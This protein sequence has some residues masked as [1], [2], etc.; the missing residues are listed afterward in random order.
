[1]YCWI[2]D[3]IL[4][5]VPADKE[6]KCI[7]FLP[8][9]LRNHTDLNR[10]TRIKKQCCMIKQ[11]KMCS[12]RDMI[13]GQVR[14]RYNKYLR[15]MQF[16]CAWSTYWRLDGERA[17]CTGLKL[18]TR[19]GEENRKLWGHFGW[20]FNEAQVLKLNTTCRLFLKDNNNNNSGVVWDKFWVGR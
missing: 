13:N 16:L 19:L 11:Q 6:V 20:C 2:E 1:M 8:E 10:N 17:T 15:S 4:G 3:T 12:S 5:G 7:T 14:S 18:W 9:L